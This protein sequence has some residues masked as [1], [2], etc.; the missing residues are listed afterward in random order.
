MVQTSREKRDNWQFVIDPD[1]ASWAW[2]RTRADG[3]IERS[4]GA[5]GSLQDCASDARTH[6]FGGWKNDERRQI[7]AGRDALLTAP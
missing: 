7:T 2:E 5:F 4:D 1:A 6:G 3:A